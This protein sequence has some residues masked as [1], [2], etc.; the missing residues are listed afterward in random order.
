MLLEHWCHC[1]SRISF[2]HFFVIIG[3]FCLLRG[4]LLVCSLI[5]DQQEMSLMIR[6]STT[7]HVQHSME[8]NTVAKDDRQLICLPMMFIREK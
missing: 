7:R 1:S 5:N 2:P 6:I 8:Y 4:G 3:F